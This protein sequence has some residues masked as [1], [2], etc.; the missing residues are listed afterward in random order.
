MVKKIA[1]LL[2]WWQ[3]RWVK[4]TISPYVVESA[5]LKAGWRAEAL[6]DVL[7]WDP[8]TWP[9][10]AERTAMRE[11]K[12]RTRELLAAHGVKLPGGTDD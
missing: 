6:P 4:V 11:S 5:P 12:R 1:R 7:S 2:R 3:M 9:T 10:E 8:S